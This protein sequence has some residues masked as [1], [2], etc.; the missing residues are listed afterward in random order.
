M[1]TFF[2]LS[3]IAILPVLASTTFFLLNKFS[4]FKNLKNRT[5]Q[6]IY[7][8]TFGCLAII[9]TEFGVNLGEVIANTRDA[10]VL[11]AGLLFGAPAGLI[12]AILGSTERFF[13]VYWGG[14]TYT[15]IA[16]TL[17][18]FLA[19]VIGST[20]RKYMF[21]DK[22][23]SVLFSLGIGLATEVLH[24]LMV[25]IT[26]MSDISTAFI[27]IQKC[28]FPMI[29]VNGFAV[30]LSTLTIAILKKHKVFKKNKNRKIATIAQNGCYALLLLLLQ[31]LAFLLQ[32]CKLK[33]QIII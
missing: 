18:T 1:R 9:G 31:L 33:F 32:F 13:C 20:L 12:A 17:S 26:N 29:V 16:C 28:A 23:P 11:T 8:I 21:N 15:Q 25:F 22:N 3:Q 30:M 4:K 14:G 24:M 27:F 6:T 5:K 10:S 7:G 19:G 2:G